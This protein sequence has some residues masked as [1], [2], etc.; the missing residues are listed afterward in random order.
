MSETSYLK[1][2]LQ[3]QLQVA[4]ISARAGN[5]AKITV[6]AVSCRSSVIVVF[7][8]PQFGMVRRVEGFEIGTAGMFAP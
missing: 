1:H 6:A 8:L 5:A 7:G 4:H 2:K 3:R